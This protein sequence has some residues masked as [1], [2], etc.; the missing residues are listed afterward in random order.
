MFKKIVAL[1]LAAWVGGAALAQAGASATERN[2]APPRSQ[3]F[4]TSCLATMSSGAFR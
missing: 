4:S 3:P 2:R 1:V